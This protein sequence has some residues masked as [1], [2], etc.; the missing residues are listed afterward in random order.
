MILPHGPISAPAFSGPTVI[1]LWVSPDGN[2]RVAIKTSYQ[3]RQGKIMSVDESRSATRDQLVQFLTQLQKA[4]FWATPTEL[5]TTK[6]RGANW[7]MEGVKDAK[8]RMVARQ[9]PDLER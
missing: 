4:N 1:T 9:C 7:I 8:Y 2:G 5:P 6:A 3:S